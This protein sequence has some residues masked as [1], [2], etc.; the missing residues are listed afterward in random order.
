MNDMLIR[1]PDPETGE[2]VTYLGYAALAVT[3]GVH[4]ST[5]HKWLSAGAVRSTTIGSR[6]FGAVQ[7]AVLT[8]LETPEQTRARGV[9][10][11]SKA[12]REA[13]RAWSEREQEKT[14][15]EATRHGQLWEATEVDLLIEMHRAGKHIEEIAIRL[16][17]TYAGVINQVHLLHESGEL[18][19]RPGDDGLDWLD[20][21]AK[22][23]T[24]D[25][26]ARVEQAM[27]ETR[28]AA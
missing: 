22:V 15:A 17:R 2:P 27:I 12:V 7:D 23:M 6:K 25:E 10:R 20:R 16:G 26:V 14:R 28:R 11:S 4:G 24:D 18:P 8:R 3:V 1:K 9:S 5:I 13:S 19:V 21:S